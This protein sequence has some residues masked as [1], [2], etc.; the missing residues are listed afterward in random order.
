MY[1]FMLCLSMYIRVCVW[2]CG[3][4]CGCGYGCV[5]VCVCVGVGMG[6][7][8]GVSAW[9]SCMR[10]LSS[11]V[12]VTKFEDLED[13]QNEL[14]LKTTLW[15]A[16]GEW[17]RFQEEWMMVRCVSACMYVCTRTYSIC[18]LTYTYVCT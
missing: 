17:D 9:C 15:N 4:G 3:C 12:E 1:I 5:C 6:V 11:Q 8:V 10:G 18:L 7:V 14:K 16:Q 13:T 2:V